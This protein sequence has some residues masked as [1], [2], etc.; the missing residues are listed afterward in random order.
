MKKILFLIAML[1]LSIN[2]VSAADRTTSVE[3]KYEPDDT[4]GVVNDVTLTFTAYIDDNNKATSWKG[5]ETANNGDDKEIIIV[6]RELDY[7]GFQDKMLK[8]VFAESTGGCPNTIRLCMA[9]PVDDGK[10]GIF[11][12]YT[13]IVI[14]I[15]SSYHNMLT[16]GETF[17]G[18]YLGKNNKDCKYFDLADKSMGMTNNILNNCDGLDEQNKQLNDYYNAKE[19]GKYRNLKDKISAFCESTL[20]TANYEIGDT[21]DA[22]GCVV[23]CLGLKFPDETSGNNLSNCGFSDRLVIW[24]A[25]VVRWIK[26]II[27]VVVMALGILDFIKAMAGDKDDEMK[28]AQGRFVKRLIAAALIF[29]APIIIEFILDKMGF[30]AN[31]C[32]IIDL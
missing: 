19:M 20:N 21:G 9:Q 31:D 30:T 26:Y 13:D 14:A 25:N 27:P 29:L 16:V 3:C 5:I 23:K 17:N 18:Y 15:D 2:V 24:I 12:W 8:S 7:V 32:G 11:N 4:D 1:F 10:N 28:K 22:N 6:D